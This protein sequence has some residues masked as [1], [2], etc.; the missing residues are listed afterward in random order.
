MI[1]IEEPAVR[2]VIVGST[3]RVFNFERLTELCRDPRPARKVRQAAVVVAKVQAKPRSNAFP[4]SQLAAL[5]GVAI[6]YAGFAY[7]LRLVDLSFAFGYGLGAAVNLSITAWLVNR[8]KFSGAEG[9]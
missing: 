7:G 2:N 3:E 6:L 4:K 5:I 8:R 1:A 9:E